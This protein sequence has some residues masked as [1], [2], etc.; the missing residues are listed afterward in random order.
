MGMTTNADIPFAKSLVDYI[1]RWLGMQFI[2]GYREQNAPRRLG[3]SHGTNIST[4][5][6]SAPALGSDSG[7]TDSTRIKEDSGCAPTSSSGSVDTGWAVRRDRALDIAKAE[8][9]ASNP[10]AS[11][12]TVVAPATSRFTSH[13]VTA[14]TEMRTADGRT[15]V[16][17]IASVERTVKTVAGNAL[18]ASNAALMGDAPACDGCGAITVRNGTCYRCLNCGNS[19]GCS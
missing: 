9:V 6:D 19:M 17:A 5:H 10:S 15:S 8:Q 4:A 18:D 12:G 14:V 2:P 7:R 3:A 11:S 13:S 1:F 16:E